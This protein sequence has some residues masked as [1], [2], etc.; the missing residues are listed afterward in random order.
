MSRFLLCWKDPVLN[1]AP[2]HECIWGSGDAALHI[3]NFGTRWK[4]WSYLTPSLAEALVSIDVQLHAMKAYG[5][6]VMQLHTFIT[7]ELDGELS[8]LTTC[9]AEALVNTDVSP[10]ASLDALVERTTSCSCCQWNISSSNI[11]L[12]AY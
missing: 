6:L 8:Y 4:K 2:C 9:P 7:L 10:R 1:W 3:H 12:A 11:Q 5:G